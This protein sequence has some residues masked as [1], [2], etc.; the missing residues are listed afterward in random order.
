M[1]TVEKEKAIKGK[2][3]MPTCRREGSILCF[4]AKGEKEKMGRGI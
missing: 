1:R 3:K 2:T 4:F